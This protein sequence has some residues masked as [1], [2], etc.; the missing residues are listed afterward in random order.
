MKEDRDKMP[1]DVRERYEKLQQNDLPAV[2]PGTD[3]DDEDEDDA[4]DDDEATPLTDTV[5]AL[6]YVQCISPTQA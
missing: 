6:P 2:A 3:V 5:F 4:D 1:P